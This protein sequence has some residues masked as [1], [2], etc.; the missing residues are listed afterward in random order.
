MK[1]IWILLL[2][3]FTILPVSHF[4]SPAQSERSVETNIWSDRTIAIVDAKTGVSRLELAKGSSFTLNVTLSGTTDFLHGF[5]VAVSFNNTI[6]KCNAVWISMSDPNQVFY[7]QS[8]PVMQFFIV[9]NHAGFVATGAT[10]GI[11]YVIPS[12]EYRHYVNVSDERL[13]CQLNFT[14]Q[15]DGNS[16]VELQTSSYY[17][18]TSLVDSSDKQMEFIRVDFSVRVSTPRMIAA[19]VVFTPSVLNLRSLGRWI[20]A[21]VELPKGYNVKEADLSTIMVNETI[22]PA[23]V[24][25]HFG[26]R[27]CLII[28]FERKAIIDMTMG[29]HRCGRGHRFER[30]TL[31][32]AGRL[33]NGEFF[34]GS[35]TLAI[36]WKSLPHN[37]R[38]PRFVGQSFRFFLHAR[39]RRV[40]YAYDKRGKSC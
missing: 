17:Y 15:A 8:G 5:Q 9:N 33:K 19:M 11:D 12:G 13:L 27:S 6:I 10:L 35:D 34:Q 16:P 31:T 14:A 32:V 18:N 36:I 1:R 30:V 26:K 28:K 37:P 20:T 3:L 4:A 29:S 21:L 38:M 22:R 24:H 23:S 40:W 25:L 2:L 7:G 39:A